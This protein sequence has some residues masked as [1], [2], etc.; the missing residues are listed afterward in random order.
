MPPGKC[1]SEQVQF[2]LRHV[3]IQTT[4]SYLRCKQKL[5]VAVN[6][7]LGIVRAAE[8]MDAAKPL[9]S[10]VGGFVSCPTSEG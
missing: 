3:S 8:R 4:E 9:L 7:R 10:S 6:D 2:L 5:R 1:E